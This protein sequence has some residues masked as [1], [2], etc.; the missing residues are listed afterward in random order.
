MQRCN[1]KNCCSPPALACFILFVN[2]ARN[3]L[4]KQNPVN[5]ERPSCLS[6]IKQSFIGKTNRNEPT[7]KNNAFKMCPEGLPGAILSTDPFLLRPRHGAQ[8]YTFLI[9]L[10]SNL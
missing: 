7:R 8:L 5:N 3:L 6:S 2:R 9:I 1:W 10:C 4:K